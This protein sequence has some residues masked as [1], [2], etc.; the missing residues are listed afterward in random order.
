MLGNVSGAIDKNRRKHQSHEPIHIHPG[1]FPFHFLVSFAFDL[2]LQ[3][4]ARYEI[5]NIGRLRYSRIRVHLR[6]IT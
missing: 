6:R 2:V 4:R 1:S 5:D 3:L